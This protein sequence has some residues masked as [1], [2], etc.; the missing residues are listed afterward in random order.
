MPHRF[1]RL[2]KAK[3]STNRGSK[4]T[5]SPIRTTDETLKNIAHELTENLLQ[6]LSVNWSERESV[7]AKLR[8]VVK[9]IL[10][11][12]KYPPDLQDGAVELVLKQAQ[13]M[14]ESWAV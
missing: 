11:K 1:S 13:V 4:A 3:A 7:R 8:L 12:Y 9:R 10:R 2:I 14:G 5:F 6:N